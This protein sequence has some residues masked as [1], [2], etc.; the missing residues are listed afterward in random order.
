MASTDA[1]YHTKPM[2]CLRVLWHLFQDL[3]VEG[4]RAVEIARLV[5]LGRCAQRRN[6]LILQCTVCIVDGAR[7][8][9]VIGRGQGSEQGLEMPLVIPPSSNRS[10]VERLSDL[11]AT[12]SRDGSLS[13]VELETI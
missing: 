3:A 4:L 11:P 6:D 7:V 2:E 8:G 9:T 1:G 12:G 13:A 5:L 10:I